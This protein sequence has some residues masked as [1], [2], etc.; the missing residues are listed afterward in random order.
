MGIK[1]QNLLNSRHKMYFRGDVMVSGY[2]YEGHQYFQ[3]DRNGPVR[4]RP[5]GCRQCADL[6][7]RGYPGC[8]GIQRYADP[9][10][11]GS[12]PARDQSGDTP[13]KTTA[14]PLWPARVGSGNR[15][16]WKVL[17]LAFRPTPR[18]A[19]A[20]KAIAFCGS[21]CAGALPPHNSGQDLL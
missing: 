15:K 11:R 8:T 16:P 9:G 10:R 12:R 2:L 3:V 20:G 19:V 1:P 5:A 7:E 17:R 21:N 6:R 13:G 4:A 18:K 14:C